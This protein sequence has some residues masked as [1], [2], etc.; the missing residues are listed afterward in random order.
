MDTHASLMDR[1]DEISGNQS[2]QKHCQFCGRFFKP[3]P[4]VGDRQISCKNEA[5]RRR[6]KQRSQ[7]AWVAQNPEYF[8]GRYEDTKAWRLNNPGY[9][10]ARRRR[11]RFKIQDEIPINSS[12][13]TIH[14]AITD[15]HLKVEIQ[16]EIRRQKAL[17][18]GFLVGG[19]PREIQDEIAPQTPLAHR[20]P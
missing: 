2:H 20:L 15:Q 18:R 7:R 6:R 8:R 4:R 17:G 3:D 10:K 5:C 9:Q 19:R 12:I 14:L 1:P 13:V 11:R 16:D